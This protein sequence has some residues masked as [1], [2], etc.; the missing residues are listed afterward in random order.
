MAR[1]R[2]FFAELQHQSAVAQ[3]N[4]A[5][6]QT[7][8][9]REQ[10]RLEREYER[11]AA[12]A[13]RANNAAARGDAKA[14]AEAEKEAKQLHLQAQIS[15]VESMNADL[16]AQLAEID[17]VLAATLAVD[18]YVDL[19]A[20]RTIAEHPPFESPYLTPV[21]MPSPIQPSPEP[22]LMLP[23]AP[24]GIGGVFKKSQHSAA[25]AAAQQEHAARLS[26]WQQ[27]V[28]AVPMRQME[29][30]TAHAT[31]E[32]ERQRLLTDHRASYAAWCAGRQAEVDAS[33]AHLDQLIAGFNAS[34]PAAVDEYIDLVLSNSV[35]PDGLPWSA[36]HAFEIATGE[37][38]I[39][40]H[41]PRPE[42]LPAAK[43]YKYVKAHDEITAIAPTAKEARDR[44]STLICSMTLRTMHEVWESDRTHKVASISLVGGVAHLHP[45]TGKDVFTPLVSIATDRATF[46][47][48]DLARVTPA[49]TLK[50][51]GAVVSKNPAALERVDAKAG[52]R[53]V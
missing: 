50:Y 34:D 31:A 51:L 16:A 6:A 7:A 4:K 43:A 39:E 5:R 29:Q 18:D 44:Y 21:P 22:V 20:L 27:E 36:E 14:A 8:A 38:R 13:L 49:E 2:G 3:K 42:D 25:V 41:F 10:A 12:A 47:E 45:G 11:A 15:R 33:N 28:A 32:Q 37:L 24:K 46:E 35:Y 30:L 17:A 1:R 23:E 48:V 19:E 52:V 9:A 40:L 26:A 53:A